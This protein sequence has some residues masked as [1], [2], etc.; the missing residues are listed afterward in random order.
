MWGAG[1]TLAGIDTN[2]TDFNTIEKTGGEKK[3]T[4]TVS[5]LPSHTHYTQGYHGIAGS[6]TQSI[7]RYYISSDPLDTGTPV[8]YT[9]GGQ[10]HN[11]LMPYITCYMYKRTA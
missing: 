7:A 3:V 2:D 4:L 5:Q 10:A 6:G 8:R 11:N 9:G 1:R